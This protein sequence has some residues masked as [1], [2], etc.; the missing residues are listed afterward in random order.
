RCRQE[1]RRSPMI[2]YA[3]RASSALLVLAAFVSVAA[4]DGG[5]ESPPSVAAVRPAEPSLHAATLTLDTHVD[6]PFDFATPTVDPR[7][8]PLQVNLEKMRRGGLDAAFFI[9]YVGQTA[10]TEENYA[11]AQRD[12][13][14]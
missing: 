4:C 13:M 11:A 3:G 1:E 2:R 10:R 8:A 9:V 14:T 5:A 12:A 6:I 7:T